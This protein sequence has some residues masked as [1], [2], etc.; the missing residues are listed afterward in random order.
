MALDLDPQLVAQAKVGLSG[1]AGGIIYHSLRP[2]KTLPKLITGLTA[3]L[4]CGLMFTHP[5]M[6]YFNIPVEYSGGVG[7]ALGLCGLAV[8]AGIL[9]AVEQFN[10]SALFKGAK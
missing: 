5:V 2:A 6:T 9:K 3:N 10:F 8:A 7:A 1:L 4:L